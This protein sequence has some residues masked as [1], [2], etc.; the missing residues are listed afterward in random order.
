MMKPLMIVVII[1]LSYTFIHTMKEIRDKTIIVFIKNVE[2]LTTVRA[3]HMRLSSRTKI[4]I[5][6]NNFYNFKVFFPKHK[7]GLN[8]VAT[9]T[10]K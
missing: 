5:W 6:E 4:S 8:S 7:L 2:A 10:F 1:Y 9:V 3:S